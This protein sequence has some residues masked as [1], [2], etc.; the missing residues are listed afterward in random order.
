MTAARLEGQNCPPTPSLIRLDT[1]P[2]LACLHCAA[3]EA[4]VL[5]DR[6]ILDARAGYATQC[7]CCDCETGSA[8][9]KCLGEHL[10]YGPFDGGTDPLS[11]YADSGERYY[12]RD[13]GA[14]GDV[15][16]TLAVLVMLPQPAHRAIELAGVPAN[17][18]E[19][20]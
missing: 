13:C 19:L 17:L 10:E 4:T 1:L 20:A 8:C 14:T 9:P 18:P 7:V 15:D 6:Q 12:C 11:G 2:P 3:T 16:D 5:R